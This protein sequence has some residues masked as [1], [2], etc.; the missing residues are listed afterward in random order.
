MNIEQLSDQIHHLT[1]VIVEQQ[2]KLKEVKAKLSYELAA[3]NV[4]LTSEV[5]NL[6][7]MVFELK[8]KV[9][10]E[11]DD[12]KPTSSMASSIDVDSPSRISREHPTR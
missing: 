9:D 1:S 5:N 8:V 7:K 4:S 6:S 2:H 12:N 10:K 3:L 11:V